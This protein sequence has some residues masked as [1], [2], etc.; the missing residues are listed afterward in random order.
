[1][2]EHTHSHDHET[3]HLAENTE[4]QIEIANAGTPL[5]IVGTD[6]DARMALDI[7][8][9]QEVIV[10]GFMTDKEEDLHK[11]INN[12]SVLMRI[13]SPEGKKFLDSEKVDVIV[14]DREISHRKSLAKKALARKSHL[15]NLIYP[16]IVISPYS[17]IGRGNLIGSSVVILANTHIGSHNSIQAG[18][19]VDS[20][21]IIQDY[22][23]IQSGA[24]IGRGVKIEDEVFIG[25]GAIIN[26]G[27]TLKKGALI[28]PGAVVIQSVSEG[29]SMVGNPAKS[30]K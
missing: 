6:A 29:V 16:D 2:H 30:M 13:D 8:N 19:F 20:D 3:H 25:M 22:C 15:V 11:E 5:I 14:V 21:T 23:T 28:A 10:Y 7:A 17:S 4:A 27:V 1:M 9:A 12:V 24:K 26:A 18:V